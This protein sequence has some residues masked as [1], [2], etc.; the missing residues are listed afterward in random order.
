[1]V[2][3]GTALSATGTSPR[4]MVALVFSVSGSSVIPYLKTVAVGTLPPRRNC[5]TSRPHWTKRTTGVMDHRDELQGSSSCA[6]IVQAT[7]AVALCYVSPR[8]RGLRD[9]P[10]G[11]G[12]RRGC[13]DCTVCTS[14]TVARRQCSTSFAA[15]QSEQELF[16]TPT[17]LSIRAGFRPTSRDA[18]RLHTTKQSTRRA[19]T[20]RSDRPFEPL[21]VILGRKYECVT[22]I[23]SVA[24]RAFD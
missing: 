18:W 16:G 19:Q 3:A 13:Y 6:A 2:G 9:S 22:W 20:G 8:G 21:A 23:Q 7:R 11:G 10:S 1:M 4:T 12:V 24:I 14:Q 5:C 17:D 15:R